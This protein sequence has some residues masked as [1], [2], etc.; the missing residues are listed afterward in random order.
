MQITNLLSQITDIHVH[1][2]KYQDLYFEPKEVTSAMKSMGLR[3]YAFS[4][5]T[6]FIND[7]DAIRR[8]V[9][10]TV[11]LSGGRALPILWVTPKMIEDSPE[12]DLFEV[13]SFFMIKIHA[14]AHFFEPDGPFVNRVF[15][16]SREYHKP[17]LIH[18]G[19]DDH[20][21]AG[22][23]ADV[24]KKYPA[25]Q[26][27]LAHGRPGDEALAVLRASENAYVDTAY[28]PLVDVELF[29]S[30]GFSDRII[31]GTDYPLDRY[32]YPQEDTSIRYENYV[33]ELV[34]AFGEDQLL[35]WGNVPWINMKIE[36]FFK[37]GPLRLKP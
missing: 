14:R 2:G 29:M 35:A 5:T 34:A 23:Y 8:E 26:T 9:E 21:D 18:T 36:E 24:I 37:D 13:S 16:I 30:E 6:S 1:I 7:Y 20:C 25:V 33:R 31:F 3:H 10:E 19:G 4:S 22:R 28:M 17:L 32:F 12:L 15:A 11:S 27:I